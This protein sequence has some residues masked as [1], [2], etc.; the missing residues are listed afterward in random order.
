MSKKLKINVTIFMRVRN[1]IEHSII[2]NRQKIGYALG[3]GAARGLFHIGVLN[4]LEE[5]DVYPDVIAGT[6][7]GSI[8]GA[9]YASGHK[10]REIKKLACSIDWKQTVRLADI[11]L[12]TRGLI[13]GR[14][15]IK[16]LKSILADIKFNQLKYEFACVAADMYTGEQIIIRSG[17]V[18]DAV[19]AS[20]SVPGIFS[21]VYREG[22]YLVDGGL[23][24]V[25]P[26]SVCL[27]MGAE[28]VIGVNAIP[29]PASRI[30]RV[31]IGGGNDNDRDGVSDDEMQQPIIPH[32]KV[33]FHNSRADAI[34]KGI[35]KFLLYRQPK[36]QRL[37]ARNPTSLLPQKTGLIRSSEPTLI[38][39]LS[40]SLNVI[41]YNI[42]MEN[43]K[44][45]DLAV[46]PL[47]ETIGFWDF[48]RADD[49]IEAGE[50]AARSVLQR[51]A[52]ARIQLDKLINR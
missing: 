52:V 46:S 17:S 8:I 28:Y 29:D 45:A 50:K 4:V 7:M 1:M 44:D 11:V 40:Q 30:M 48:H 18:I 38:E 15:I 14:R 42:A 10:A 21:P 23:V 2:H 22:R 13:Q 31:K 41:E 49:A 37:V 6:S 3:G 20:I 34:N 51:D 24:N 12:P 26:V 47:S 9:L 16:L 5:H 35:K 25:V 43:I 19:R 27:D 36:L 32:T 33:K 39:V